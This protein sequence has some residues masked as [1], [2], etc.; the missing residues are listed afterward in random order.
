M[1]VQ[2]TEKTEND[3]TT[4]GN[5]LGFDLKPKWKVFGAIFQY[6]K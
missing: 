5:C 4:D 6:K 1:S 2:H 3:I